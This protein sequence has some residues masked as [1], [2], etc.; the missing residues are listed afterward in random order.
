[1]FLVCVVIKI[2][3]DQRS[4]NYISIAGTVHDGLPPLTL[5]FWACVMNPLYMYCI[6]V[7][8]WGR[9]VSNSVYSVYPVLLVCLS[10]VRIEM[11]PVYIVIVYTLCTHVH[12]YYHLQVFYVLFSVW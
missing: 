3:A 2:I 5:V 10:F 1:M 9:V 11:P 4:I 6:G 8:V 12:V 7:F